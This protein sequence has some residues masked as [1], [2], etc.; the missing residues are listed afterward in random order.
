MEFLKELWGKLL[1]INPIPYLLALLVL[2]YMFVK[3][4]QYRQVKTAAHQFNSGATDDKTVQLCQK[5]KHRNRRPKNA[6]M[7]DVFCCI[8]CAM[9]L[10][11]KEE[12]LFFENL[13]SVKAMTRKIAWRVNLLLVAYLT[14]KR[15]LDLSVA[16]KEEKEE[17]QGVQDWIFQQDDLDYEPERLATLKAKLTQ[18][19]VIEVLDSLVDED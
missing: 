4:V 17:D 7:H 14:G 5:L 3:I 19:Q 15:Y 18:D 12:E 2:T 1:S 13:N 6:E 11:R 8:L 9:H 16:Y 10:E